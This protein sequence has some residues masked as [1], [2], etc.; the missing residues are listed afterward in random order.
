[1]IKYALKYYGYK[2]LNRQHTRFEIKTAY[3]FTFSLL[4]GLR[5]PRSLKEDIKAEV[6]SGSFK[7]TLRRIAWLMRFSVLRRTLINDDYF[8]FSIGLSCQSA[9]DAYSYVKAKNKAYKDQVIFELTLA[10]LS[11]AVIESQLEPG[12]CENVNNLSYSEFDSFYEEHISKAEVLI[13]DAQKLARF[14]GNETQTEKSSEFK[15]QV[16]IVG[17]NLMEKY[18]LDVLRHVLRLEEKLKIKFFVISGTFLGLHRES[19]FLAHDYDIDLGIFEDEFDIDM[20]DGFY[21]LEGFD[22]VSLDYPC[23]REKKEG[24]ATYSKTRVPALIKLIHNSGVQVDVFVHFEDGPVYWH[25]SSIH[26]WDNVKFDLVERDFFD[27]KVLAPENA[28]QYLTENYGDW[29]TPVS[30]FNC[31]TGTPNVVISNSCKTRCYFL[32]K[33]YLQSGV[34]VF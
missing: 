3:I 6:L 20:L 18:G 5:L 28:D 29:R 8:D 16:K 23:F 13:N 31:S 24:I 12:D 2:F 25:G 30:D 34:G 7:L 26:R 33:E 32:K 1:M 15:K 11:S 19:G 17:F 27:M 9:K 22:S 21:Q 10:Q 4:F 14:K